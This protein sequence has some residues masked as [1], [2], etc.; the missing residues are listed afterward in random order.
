MNTV[1]VTAGTLAVIR[2]TGTSGV[3]EIAASAQGTEAVALGHAKF[4]APSVTDWT[5]VEVA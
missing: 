3:V 2:F 1:V 5:V 4:V